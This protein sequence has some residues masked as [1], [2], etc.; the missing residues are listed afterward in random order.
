M[1]EGDS[2]QIILHYDTNLFSDVYANALLGYF[3]EVLYQL[4]YQSN[5]LL[6]DLPTLKK[7]EFEAIIKWNATDKSYPLHK[8]VHELFEEQVKKTPFSTAVVYEG[9]TLSYH[10]LNKR[11]NQLA[12]SLV[13]YG[14]INEMQVAVV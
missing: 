10:L 7:E 8:T 13:Q 5:M 1:N 2:L 12:H 11:A 14:V 9:Q 6:S 4:I 3:E